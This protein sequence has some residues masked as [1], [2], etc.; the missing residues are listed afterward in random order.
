MRYALAVVAAGYSGRWEDLPCSRG[1][2]RRLQGKR[3]EPTYPALLLQ[4]SSADMRRRRPAPWP[5]EAAG[6]AAPFYGGPGRAAAPGVA[7]S[8]CESLFI[9]SHTK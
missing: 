7:L 1:E 2:V 3:L 5:V 6:L 8:A 4:G 9:K